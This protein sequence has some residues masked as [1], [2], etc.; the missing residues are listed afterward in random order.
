M[1]PR[2]VN[3]TK[4]K[5]SNVLMLDGRRRTKGL[6]KLLDY[7][8]STFLLFIPYFFYIYTS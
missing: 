3:K 6:R 2:K 8:G 7:F 5:G 4:L 1:K